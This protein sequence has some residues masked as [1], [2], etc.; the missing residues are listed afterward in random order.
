MLPSSSSPFALGGTPPPPLHHHNPLPAFVGDY[1]AD[2]V[3]RLEYGDAP[4]DVYDSPV[5]VRRRTPVRSPSM[6]PRSRRAAAQLPTGFWEGMPLTQARSPY[7]DS[8]FQVLDSPR[9]P[10]VTRSPLMPSYA[11]SRPR[12]PLPGLPDRSPMRVLPRTIPGMAQFPRPASST[13]RRLF[14]GPDSPRSP[15]LRR[16]FPSLSTSSPSVRTPPFQP[17]D[18]AVGPPPLK[19][20]VRARS[21]E[22]PGLARPVPLPPR[23][24]L[25]LPAFLLDPDSETPPSAGIRDRSPTDS[26]LRR[27]LRRNQSRK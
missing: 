1:L 25:P 23:Q 10:S 16:L 21:S 11:P 3:D 5:L 27:H 2:E 18:I 4:D 7:P 14:A 20:F 13:N 15:Q 12:L 8:P 9:T 22:S 17:R 24:R 6:F 26:E 19:R